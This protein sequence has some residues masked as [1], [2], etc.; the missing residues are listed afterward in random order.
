[1]LVGV[2]RAL[3]AAGSHAR[4]VALEPNGLP[5]LTAGH[6][7][8]HRVEGTAP[9][10]VPPHLTPA[11][12]DEARAIDEHEARAMA[13]RLARE[14][15]IF[16]GTSSGSTSLAA[17]ELDA[18]SARSVA[19]MRAAVDSGLKYLG[20]ISFGARVDCCRRDGEHCARGTGTRLNGERLTGSSSCSH[21]I[22]PRHG[23]MRE[24]VADQVFSATPRQPGHS[25]GGCPTAGG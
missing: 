14:E 3:K 6:G 2:S 23:G 4:I 16:A 25:P 22:H 5:M 15:G 19:L 11:D 10:F 1:M 12:Y 9:G 7:G 20:G 21:L 8:P 13:R 24:T 18:S 17:L